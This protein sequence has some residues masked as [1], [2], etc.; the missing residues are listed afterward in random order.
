MRAY[1]DDSSLAPITTSK[2]IQVVASTSDAAV[3]SASTPV[4]TN[5]VAGMA[6]QVQKVNVTNTGTQPLQISGASIA[7]TNGPAVF[8]L[9]HD[10][11]SG[12][13]VAPGHSCFV[14]VQFAP[15][16]ADVTST[17]SLV[18]QSN[19]AEQSNSV[20]LTGTSTD[21]QWPWGGDS[22]AQ[23]VAPTDSATGTGA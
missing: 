20:T 22:P 18:L 12:R 23:D 8:S 6:G 5:Q 13:T 11:C 14:S 16:Q 21:L 19:T 4:F 1:T 10:N 17:A 9:K 7:S 15:A 3:L 2:T